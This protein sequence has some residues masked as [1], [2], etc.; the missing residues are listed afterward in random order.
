MKHFAT[1][2]LLIVMLVSC[3]DSDATPGETEIVAAPTATTAPAATAVPTNTPEPTEVP[4]APDVAAIVESGVI[5]V[6]INDAPLLPFAIVGD[7]PTEGFEIDLAEAVV[8][9]AF[10]DA[11]MIEWVPVSAENRLDAIREGDI[12]L[13]IRATT[14][15]VSRDADAL[16]TIPY[17]LD[18]QRV[19]VSADSGITELSDLADETICVN[20]GT[21]W[22]TNLLAYMEAEGIPIETLEMGADGT[23][24]FQGLCP[25]VTLDWSLIMHL[26]LSFN[27]MGGDEAAWTSIGDSMITQVDGEQLGYEPFA[28][29]VR[30]DA[31]GL[32]AAIDSALV[33]LIEDGTWQTLYDEWMP[34]QPLWTLEDLLEAQPAQR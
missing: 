27:M 32:H 6:G 14:H 28:V 26:G 9:S 23:P 16:W 31:T 8:N 21:D 12:D 34:E 18:G 3:A 20:M 25:A 4:I 13:L 17:F 2:L 19:L 1:L 22:E 10:G 24:F 5:R 33:E 15:T 7:G 29:G 11:V 30:P